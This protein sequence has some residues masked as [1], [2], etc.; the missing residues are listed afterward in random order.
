MGMKTYTWTHEWP[1]YVLEATPMFIAMVA[2]GWY[3]PARWIPSGLRAK[4]E[5]IS[6]A[7]SS[8]PISLS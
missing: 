3:H 5:T 2:L 1:L 6:S 7:R 4:R 8:E